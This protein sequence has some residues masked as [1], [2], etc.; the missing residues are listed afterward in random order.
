MSGGGPA[1]DLSKLIRTAISAILEIMAY[2][3]EARV[4]LL[5]FLKTCLVRP[6]GGSCVI[7]RP[8]KVFNG[9]SVLD[10]T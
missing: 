10:E 9:S 5:S 2:S 7:S 6:S 4:I 1:L 3:V 8:V